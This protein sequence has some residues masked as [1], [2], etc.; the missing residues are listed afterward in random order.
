MIHSKVWLKNRWHLLQRMREANRRGWNSLG[1]MF[2]DGINWNTLR[3]GREIRRSNRLFRI[4]NGKSPWH[5][6]NGF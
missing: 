5:S 4:A 3:W 6:V 2:G 1:P